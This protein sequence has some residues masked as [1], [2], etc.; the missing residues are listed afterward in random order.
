MD[1][2]IG[3]E[4]S[5]TLDPELKLTG[6]AS[7][8]LIAP[9]ADSVLDASVEA[10]L[11]SV[12]RPLSPIRIA[13]ALGLVSDDDANAPQTDAKPKAR[14]GGKANTRGAIES[15]ASAVSRL[16]QA[17]A[18][19]GRSFRVESVAGGYRVMTLP[20]HAKVLEAYHGRRERTGLSRA[21]IETLAIIAYKQPITR[22]TLEA[23]RGVATGDILRSLL[24]RRLVTIA[25]RAEE[26]GRPM[27]YATTPGFLEAFGLRSLKDLPSVEEFAHRQ[28]RA[29][30]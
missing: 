30:D 1:V 6:P 13:Q 27:L 20:E 5:A 22:A 2:S 10:L 14:R 18:S 15:V 7:P 4:A 8:A 16:N 24:E 9:L 26:L 25:G 21:A 11:V 12:D 28:D 19:S 29:D 3:T 23:I 17:Y